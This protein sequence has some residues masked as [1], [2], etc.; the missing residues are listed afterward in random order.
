MAL[1]GLRHAP[2]LRG[3]WLGPAWKQSNR[4]PPLH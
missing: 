2:R 4:A 1:D 3:E